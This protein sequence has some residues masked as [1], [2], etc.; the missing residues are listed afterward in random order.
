[1]TAHRILSGSAAAEGNAGATSPAPH[2]PPTAN[3]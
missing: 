3:H 1:V 2:Q